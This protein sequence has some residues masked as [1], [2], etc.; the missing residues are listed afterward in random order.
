[1]KIAV[2]DLEPPYTHYFRLSNVKV[3]INIET[4]K[5]KRFRHRA[6]AWESKL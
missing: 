1:M 3:L 6:R 5:Y 2:V 4:A